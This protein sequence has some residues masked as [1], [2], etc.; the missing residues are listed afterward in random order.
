MK[1][2][3]NAK[4]ER[5]NSIRKLQS[6]KH[7]ELPLDTEQDSDMSGIVSVIDKECAGDLKSILLKVISIVLGRG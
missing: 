5:G 2:K 7:T 3:Q 1:R 6:Y 4:M